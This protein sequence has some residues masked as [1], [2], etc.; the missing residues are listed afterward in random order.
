MNMNRVI[1]YYGMNDGKVE[2]WICKLEGYLT[3]A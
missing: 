1:D 3:G 2:F